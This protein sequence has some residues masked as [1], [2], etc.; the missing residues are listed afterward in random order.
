MDYGCICL[1]GESN[2]GCIVSQFSTMI[3]TRIHVRRPEC[4]YGA[5]TIGGTRLLYQG[6]ATA[7]CLQ[8][9]DHHSNHT[10]RNMG[11]VFVKK[12]EI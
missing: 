3:Q 12:Y 5:L 9:I 8:E 7:S 4:Q 2:F 6:D 1:H 11:H 10:R